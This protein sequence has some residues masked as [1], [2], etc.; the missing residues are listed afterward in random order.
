M[1]I[2]PE[3]HSALLDKFTS[4][5]IRRGGTMRCSSRAALD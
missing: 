5:V 4:S 3:K 1:A 2:E